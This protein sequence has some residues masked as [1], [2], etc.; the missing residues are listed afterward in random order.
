MPE[1]IG[2]YVCHCGSNIAGTVDVEDVAK[3]AG[4][5]L[6]D[7]AVAVDYRFMCSSL[8]QQMMGGDIKTKG[9]TRVIVAACSPSLHEKTF[10]R[11]CKNAGLNPYLFQMVNLREHVAWV[12]RDKVAATLKAKSLVAAGAARVALQQPLEPTY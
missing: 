6:K 3:W 4:E 1:K 2:I 11:A 8:G 10:R 12:H 9:L 5:N 7:V